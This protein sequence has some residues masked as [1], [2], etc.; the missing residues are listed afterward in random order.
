MQKKIK[1]AICCISLVSCCLLFAG[2]NDSAAP[3]ES[4][5]DTAAATASESSDDTAKATASD[6]D[7]N[8]EVE[9]ETKKLTITI[10]NLCD[11]DIGMVAVI[12]PATDEQI[13]LNSLAS[14]ES[15]SMEATWPAS[16]KEFQWA[17][18]NTEGEL[19]TE[20]KTDISEAQ[21]SVTL[22]LNGSSTVENIDENIQ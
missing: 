15:I 2:C 14:G 12:D 13:N 20:S 18:Y 16:A 22:V 17:L 7:A 11:F 9:S 5:N 10:I 1:Q 19:C 4:S 6:V 21:T 8:A 3:S